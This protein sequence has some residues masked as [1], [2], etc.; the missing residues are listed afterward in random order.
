MNLLFVIRTRLFSNASSSCTAENLNVFKWDS[1]SAMVDDFVEGAHFL[2]FFP[3]CIVE[4]LVG[5]LSL[6]S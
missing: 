5:L 4:D 1:N 3:C 6:S 2:L